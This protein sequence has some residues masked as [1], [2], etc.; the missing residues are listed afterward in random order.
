MTVCLWVCPMCEMIGEEAEAERHMEATG[1]AIEQVPQAVSDGI[2]E[3]WAKRGGFFLEG[4][5]SLA[6]LRRSVD[7][8]IKPPQ[9]EIQHGRT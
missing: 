7:S 3:V 8:N 1:H 2:R 9:K 6:S 5:M 4:L